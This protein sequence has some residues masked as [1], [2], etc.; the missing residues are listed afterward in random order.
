M[1]Q[2]SPAGG[3]CSATQPVGSAASPGC[4]LP[5]FRNMQLWAYALR[6]SEPPA[7]APPNCCPCSKPFYEYTDP[8][9]DRIYYIDPSTGEAV[10]DKPD[11][12]MWAESVDNDGACMGA[13][14]VH[15]RVPPVHIHCCLQVALREGPA[16]WPSC[17]RARVRACARAR[18]RAC[19]LLQSPLS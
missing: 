11:E 13:C 7:L 8:A 6:H 19:C 15:A 17:V 9:T 1:Q 4:M 5:A 12:L 10:W 3:G 2:R 16:C 14:T 18:V